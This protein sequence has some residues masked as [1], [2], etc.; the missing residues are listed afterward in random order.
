MPSND[1]TPTI[2]QCSQCSFYANFGEGHCRR[3]PPDVQHAWPPVNGS[4]WCG[5][6]RAAAAPLV[7]PCT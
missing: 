2:I 7:A 4:D 3:Y 1:S 6:W 5:E